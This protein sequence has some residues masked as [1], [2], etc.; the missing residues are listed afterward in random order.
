[1]LKVKPLD[2]FDYDLIKEAE[3]VIEKK[4]SIWS[5]SYWRSS[6]DSIW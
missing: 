5:T 6:E 3:K 1:M 4:L 2:D